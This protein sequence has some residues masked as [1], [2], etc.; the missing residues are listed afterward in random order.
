[1]YTKCYYKNRLYG[2]C[3]KLIHSELYSKITN[4][5]HGMLWLDVAV[6]VAMPYIHTHRDT[7]T[8]TCTWV[9]Q[10]PGMYCIF[11][12]MEYYLDFSHGEPNRGEHAVRREVECET[13]RLNEIEGKCKYIYVN[14]VILFFSLV[15]QWRE[16]CCCGRIRKHFFASFYWQ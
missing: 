16:C 15:S 13:N 6:V 2:N 4:R 11:G 10:W 9:R 12:L 3:R 8:H 14:C 7:C 1:M 5:L